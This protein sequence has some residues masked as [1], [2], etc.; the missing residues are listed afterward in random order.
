[1]ARVDGL[2]D[3]KGFGTLTAAGRAKL[4]MGKNRDRAEGVTVGKK[5]LTANINAVV[6]NNLDMLNENQKNNVITR[7]QDARKTRTVYDSTQAEK[8]HS[9]EMEKRRLKTDRANKVTAL[10]AT[11]HSVEDIKNVIRY[12]QTNV[13]SAVDDFLS[14]S[15]GYPLEVDG[16]VPP[17]PAMARVLST[18]STFS[19]SS[20]DSL[21]NLANGTSASP[22][23]SSINKDGIASL[24]NNKRKP[25]IKISGGD[26]PKK[27]NSKIKIEYS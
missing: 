19:A 26:S 11:F 16:V 10:S 14:L 27:K 20:N 23:V 12:D 4:A 13:S 8:A 18:N 24:A 1:M 22:S 25:T 9:K 3:R 15:G 17:A 5:L 7:I 6:K 21:S 2:S